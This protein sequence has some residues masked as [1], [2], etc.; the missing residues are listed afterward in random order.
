MVDQTD[1]ILGKSK[2]SIQKS[3]Q[4][5]VKKKF[6]EDPKVRTISKDGSCDL[7]KRKKI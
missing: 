2:A 7:L 1:D 4:R 3:L 6:A 5:V